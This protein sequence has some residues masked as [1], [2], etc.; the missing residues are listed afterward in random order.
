M[1]SIFLKLKA[2]VFVV[3]YSSSALAMQNGGGGGGVEPPMESLCNSGVER[4]N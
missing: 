2:L 1:I 3:L 4:N